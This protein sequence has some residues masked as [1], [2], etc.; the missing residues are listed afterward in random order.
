MSLSERVDNALDR[1]STSKLFRVISPAAM[2]TPVISFAI[3]ADTEELWEI[4]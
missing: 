3:S 1:V 4:L 2:V